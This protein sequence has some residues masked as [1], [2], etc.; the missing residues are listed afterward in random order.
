[1]FEKKGMINSA[2][3]SDGLRKRKT[4]IELLNSATARLLVTMTFFEGILGAKMLRLEW[5]QESWWR[6][7]EVMR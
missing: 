3:C 5:I 7:V 6:R 2:K 1:M 4:E